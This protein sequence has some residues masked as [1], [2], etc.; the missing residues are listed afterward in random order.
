M[1][2]VVHPNLVHYRSLSPAIHQTS[3]AQANNCSKFGSNKQFLVREARKPDSTT[4]F[5]AD[6][7]PAIAVCWTNWIDQQE[8]QL[9]FCLGKP[10][11]PNLGMRHATPLGGDYVAHN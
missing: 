3:Y 6:Q 11:E 9:D 4:R 1:L 7:F 10:C 8:A 5:E 2:W